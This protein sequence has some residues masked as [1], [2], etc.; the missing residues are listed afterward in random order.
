MLIQ[1][2]AT[3]SFK[4]YSILVTIYL[5]KGST[6]ESKDIKIW[7]SIQIYTPFNFEHKKNRNFKNLDRKKAKKYDS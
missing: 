2:S 6:M 1:C 3:P 5:I 4:Y 7:G